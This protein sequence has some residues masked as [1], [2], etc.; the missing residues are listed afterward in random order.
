MP[1]ALAAAERSP[2]ARRR[3]RGEARLLE[4]CYGHSLELARLHALG[5]IAFPCISTGVHGYPKTKA[6]RVAVEVLSRHLDHFH[7]L[8]VCCF[9]PQDARPYRALL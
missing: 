4:S 5:S 1:V 9:T 3:P 8:V 6:V 2:L 7:R